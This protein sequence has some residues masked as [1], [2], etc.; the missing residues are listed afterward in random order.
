MADAHGGGDS[1]ARGL[2][3][4]GKLHLPNGAPSPSRKSALAAASSSSRRA[5]SSSTDCRLLE[6]M[7]RNHIA[8]RVLLGGVAS[9]PL[10]AKSSA[11]SVSSSAMS[12]L[13]RPAVKPFLMSLASS[14]LNYSGVPDRHHPCCSD[15]RLSHRWSHCVAVDTDRNGPRR[16]AFHRTTAAANFVV[17]F[18]R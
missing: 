12:S 10:L 14:A 6:P 15:I 1:S 18:Q 8:N 9:A 17:T 16:K 5:T 13:D 2:T 11:A 3:A 7:Q 4:S